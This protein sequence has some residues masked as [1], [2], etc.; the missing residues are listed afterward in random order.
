MGGA[1][2]G[3]SDVTTRAAPWALNRRTAFPLCSIKSSS[4]FGTRNEV[5]ASES[6]QTLCSVLGFRRYRLLVIITRPF[7]PLLSAYHI[8]HIHSRRHSFLLSVLAFKKDKC[9]RREV[10]RVVFLKD[11]WVSCRPVLIAFNEEEEE[12][13]AMMN[14]V[15]ESN[16]E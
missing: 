6:F 10:S 16:K 7:A 5:N 9:R 15:Q 1:L 4:S 8:I 2:S 13:Y 14:D 12:G 3:E 11:D